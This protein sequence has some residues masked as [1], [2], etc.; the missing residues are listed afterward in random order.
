MDGA[1]RRFGAEQVRGADLHAAAPSAS[2]AATPC[3]SAMPP[4]AITGTLTARDDLR[5]QRERADLRGRGRRDRNMPRW[6]PASRPCAMI[7]ST[8]RASSQRA[9]S[10][11]VADE[12]TFAPQRAHARQQLRR[13]QA[14]VEAHDRR[15]GTP[16]ARRPPRRRTARAAGPPAIAS[17]SRP[18]SGSTG[19]APPA[20]PPRARASAA[21]GVWQKK[22]T[23]NGL[24]GLRADRG[25]LRCASPSGPSMRA[26]QRAEPAGVA[27][28]R[29]PARCPARPPSA[30]G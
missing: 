9:S 16:R 19:R 20:R 17:G 24:V 3:A 30:P 15:A 4:A 21:G 27:T 18:S 29:S 26:R 23:L 12:R 25:E 6:P 14:E 2:A 1:G 11:V 28:R 8:P 7:A 10:T 22:L 5:H 13:R